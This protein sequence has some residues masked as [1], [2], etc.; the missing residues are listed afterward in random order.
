MLDKGMQTSSP[1]MV[2]P[3]RNVFA[4][5]R[6]YRFVMALALTMAVLPGFGTGLLLVLVAGAGLPVSV[7]WPQLAQSHGQVQTFGFV[8]LF[9]VA[10]GLQLFPRFLGAPLIHPW[11]AGWGASLV[12]ISLLAREV[13]QPLPQT[14]VRQLLLVVA[15]VGVP[16][17]ALMAGSAFH[18]LT[19]RSVQPKRGPAAAWRRFIAVGGMSLG[20]ALVL[21]VWANF[22][23]ATGD[24]VVS[25]GLDE[26]LIHLELA[27]FATCLV[28]GVS[29]RVFGRFLLLRTRPQ[30][31]PW[32]PRLALTWA[33]GLALV[34]GG[35]LLAVP[36]FKAM[37]GLLELGVLC[38]WLWLIGLYDA[39]T[40]PSGTPYVT[41]PTRRWIR[42]GFALLVISLALD[43]A[44]FAR[45]AITGEPPGASE[46]SAARHALA[47]GFLLALMIS[48][49]SRLLPIYS[50]DVLKHRLRLELTVDLVLVGAIVR[51]VAEAGGGYTAL[52]GPLVALGGTL[53]VVGFVVF[54]IGMLASLARV[55]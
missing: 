5:T 40:R 28:F 12:A 39:P 20:G 29:S 14:P 47:Q 10:V 46:L 50:A 4:V 16:I 35:W 45:E 38:T 49:A 19:R 7:A 31:E 53:G 22:T 33:A 32:I 15:A 24:I 21:F 30:L 51:V 43:L 36:E 2:A 23:L 13:A 42:L 1:A 8:L 11:R 26:A 18:G 48:M 3:P 17:G 37:G 6:P 25:E 52:T 27:G 34:V 55:P 44:L 9:I 54:A 41:N